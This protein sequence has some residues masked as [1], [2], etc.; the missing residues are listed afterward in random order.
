M[1]KLLF[2]LFVAALTLAGVSG[3]RSGGGGGGSAGCGCGG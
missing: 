2:A 1:R 3:C